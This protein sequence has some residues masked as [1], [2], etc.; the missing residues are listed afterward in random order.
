MYSEIRDN[1][2]NYIQEKTGFK[3]LETVIVNDRNINIL[4]KNE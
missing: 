1:I 4:S 2:D 3:L